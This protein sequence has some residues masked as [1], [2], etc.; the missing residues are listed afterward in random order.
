MNVKSF[1]KK[2]YKCGHILKRKN[3]NFYKKISEKSLIIITRIWN[4]K[5]LF[6]L[7]LVTYY[8]F[9][10]WIVINI[11]IIKENILI[12]FELL[13]Y[14]LILINILIENILKHIFNQ[15]V[16]SFWRLLEITDNAIIAACFTNEDIYDPFKVFT[17]FLTL[18]YKKLKKK[19]S[20]LYEKILDSKNNINVI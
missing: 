13:F 5:N 6:I 2:I 11:H 3:I 20:G 17:D 18:W 12:C 16:K 15:I 9:I 14:F 10:I 7:I 19:L 8:K 1:I 4:K